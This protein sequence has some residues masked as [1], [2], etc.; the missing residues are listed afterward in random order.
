MTRT[1]HTTVREFEELLATE[2]RRDGHH[3]ED[4]GGI[5]IATILIVD[6]DGE[7]HARQINLSRYAQVMERKL[8]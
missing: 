5:I 2:F 1:I 3:V 7:P 8:S 4:V 6:G